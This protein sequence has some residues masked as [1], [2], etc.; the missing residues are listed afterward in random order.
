[1]AKSGISY[2]VVVKLGTISL[3]MVVEWYGTYKSKT[4][5]LDSSNKLIEGSKRR[6]DA[7]IVAVMVPRDTTK[8]HDKS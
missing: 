1:M 2:G 4:P 3:N 8:C 7:S 6:I 5:L